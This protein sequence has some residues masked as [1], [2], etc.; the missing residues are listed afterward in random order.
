MKDENGVQINSTV[1]YRTIDLNDIPELS[2]VVFTA[3]SIKDCYWEIESER[4]YN[5]FYKGIRIATITQLSTY[6]EKD[7]YD[8]E[9]DHKLVL[10][11][12]K[13]ILIYMA[14]HSD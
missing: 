2:E 5:L 12:I 13:S 14:P 7:I 10:E 4:M 3:E 9:N 11:H 8:H 1:R 6:K